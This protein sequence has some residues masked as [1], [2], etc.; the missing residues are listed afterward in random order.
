M[1]KKKKNYLFALEIMAAA[2]LIIVINVIAGRLNYGLEGDEVFSYISS[3]SM[4]GFKGI[5]YLDDHTWYDADYFRNAVI[6]TGSERFNVKMVAE[7]QAMD[8]HPPLYYL[9]LNLICSVFEG[10]YSRWFGIGLNIFF[11]LFVGWGLYLLLQYFVQSKLISL[12]SATIF[13]C[14]FLAVNMTLFIRMYV[15]T[16]ALTL[17]QSWYH[18][19]IY[20]KV[21]SANE[22]PF[23]KYRKD[24]ILLSMLT[25]AGGLTHYY[26]LIY[27]CLISAEFVLML[28]IRKRY[29]DMFRYTA[30]MAASALIYICL[31]PA[32]L[33]HLFFKYRGRDAVHKFLKESGLFDEALSMLSTFNRQLFKGTLLIIIL[34]LFC[35]TVFLLIKKKLDL[36]QLGKL[37]FLVLPSVIYFYGISKA[38]PF[39]TIRYISP[40]AAL[41]YAAIVVWAKMFIDIAG[42]TETRKIAGIFL[43]ICLFF[44][45]FYF[46]QRPV[47][48]AYFAERRDVI[49][50][51]SKECQYCVYVGDDMAYWRMWE[52]Y[53]N[54]PSFRGLYFIDGQK[55]APITDER[56]LGQENLVIYIDTN[57]DP[58]D[59]LTYLDTYLPSYQ[60]EQKYM[61]NYTYIVS[62]KKMSG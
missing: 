28:F 30:V 12:V 55:K 39:I 29:R 44:T 42:R 60:Y 32:S 57:L 37:G 56:L 10:R 21:V 46:F 40:I 25:I 48:D 38:S 62:G 47:K 49:N 22:Y 54:Y 13:C 9:F 3:T 59:I 1:D 14:S 23:R 52:D 6:A 2:V 53:I 16:M 19:V 5:C 20:D 31:Y 51:L 18:L 58:E 35:L 4:G 43:C 41:L 34:L 7:N 27:Q 24:Y 45:S 33:Q 8:T 61:T 26:F 15:L 11:M 17:F 50:E 36:V